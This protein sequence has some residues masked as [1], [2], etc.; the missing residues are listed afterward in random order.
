V[1]AGQA[2]LARQLTGLE[3]HLGTS[4]IP[5]RLALL[6]QRLDQPDR[7]ERHGPQVL[8]HRLHLDHGLV[9]CLAHLGQG[10]AGSG[11]VGIEPRLGGGGAH[12]DGEQLLLDRV[13][14]IAGES[15]SLLLRGSLAH[16]AQPALAHLAE[17]QPGLDTDS[18]RR[19]AA[20]AEEQVAEA[21]GQEAESRGQPPARLAVKRE[22]RQLLQRCHRA[23]EQVEQEEPRHHVA[24]RVGGRGAPEQ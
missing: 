22:H 19:D 18:G 10:G 1:G 14:E 21:D 6:A 24:L 20:G 11:R 9:R 5:R 3:R 2:V 13:V 7:G 23:G 17:R 15:A 4:A 8:Q 16:L 12:V